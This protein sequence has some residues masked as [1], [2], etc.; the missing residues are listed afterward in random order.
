MDLQ[1][2]RQEYS[3]NSLD[4]TEVNTDPFRQFEQW[5]GEAL[6][7]QVTEPNAFTLA[8]VDEKGQP[9]ARV[10]LL[11]GMEGYKFVFYT[12][13]GSDKG[14]QIRTNP[15]VSM[16]FFWAELERQV[17]INGTATPVPDTVSEAYFK[18]R[19]HGSQLGAHASDQS[20]EVESRAWLEEKFRKIEERFNEGEVPK[21]GNWGGYEIEATYFEFWQGRQSRL[22]DRIAYKQNGETWDIVRLSP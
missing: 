16:C 5:F 14:A 13:Y 22:H 8:T 7:S 10:V 18:S 15:N 19:P 17:R 11:K 6:D 21:P 9:H 12:N 1:K 3:R 4:E 20:E 2:L